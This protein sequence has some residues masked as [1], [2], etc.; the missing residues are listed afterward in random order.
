MDECT[1]GSGT[2]S[3]L[4][5]HTQLLEGTVCLLDLSDPRHLAFRRTLAL[6]LLIGFAFSFPSFRMRGSGGKVPI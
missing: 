4:P 2:L 3:N 1:I 5:L 6:A